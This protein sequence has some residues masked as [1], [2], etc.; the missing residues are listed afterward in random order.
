MLTKNDLQQIR[1]VVKDE[2]RP[3]KKRIDEFELGVEQRFSAMDKKV[4][5]IRETT[6]DILSAVMEDQADQGKRIKQ[7]EK[8]LDIPH[9]E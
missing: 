9:S 7:I 3:I 4:D 8:R 1:D 6:T 2:V 5:E